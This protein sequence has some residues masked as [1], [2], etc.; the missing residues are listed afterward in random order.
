MKE[1]QHQNS[2]LIRMWTTVIV[3][4]IFLLAGLFVA[5][6]LIYEIRTLLLLLILSIFFCYL[7]A[8]IVHILEQPIYIARYELR[9]PRS[10]AIG[11]VYLLIAVVVFVGIQL[12]WPPL[13]QQVADLAKN[14]PGYTES[15][16][17]GVNKVFNDA[18]SWMR[19]VKLPPQWRD[20]VFSRASDLAT[21]AA[22]W[23][24]DS[25][26]GALGYL[27]YLTWP[28]LLPIL[29]FFLL[30][31]AASFE[32]NLIALLPNERLQKRAHWLLMDVSRTLAAYIRAQITACIVVSVVVMIGLSVIKAPYPVVLGAIAGLLEFIPLIGPLIAA[33]IIFGLTLTA[34]F[35]T[36][37]MVALFLA[38]LRLAQ[39]YFIYPRIIGQGIKMHT[40]VVILAILAGA[41]IGGLVGVFLSIPALGL[42]MVFYNHYLAYRGIQQLRVVVP[43]EDAEGQT[44]GPGGV[45]LSAMPLEK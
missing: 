11:F 10:V 17:S 34:S 22:G 37:L 41:E 39:D 30:K 13:S 28:I 21:A 20:A 23:M 12:I 4:V 16:K 33:C 43:S 35:K 1:R 29:S 24:T 5:C 45:Q 44:E 32:Q 19:H 2:E 27:Q 26:A 38:I 7:I 15:A 9:L 14:L 3:R 25:L 36:A 40:L 6:W 31:D 18:N 42:L 8:P